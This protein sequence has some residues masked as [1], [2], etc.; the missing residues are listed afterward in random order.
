LRYKSFF[1][2]FETFSAYVQFF[3]LNDLIDENQNI[4]FYLPFGG[5][6]TYPSFSG[7]EEYLIYKTNVTA[8]IKSRN[9]RIL[10]LI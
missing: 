3:L 4:K 10:E 5:F 6:K 9:Q 2:L 7:V 1:D 8:F